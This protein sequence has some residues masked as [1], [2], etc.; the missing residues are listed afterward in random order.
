MCEKAKTTDVRYLV[1]TEISQKQAYIFRSNKLKENI[2]NSMVIETVLSKE[3]FE[4]KISSEIYNT[5]ENYVY[6]GGGHVILEFSTFEKAEKFVQSLTKKIHEEYDELEVF[7]K[8][9]GYDEKRAPGENLKNLTGCLEKKKALR[10]SA[11]HQG[12]FGIEKIDNNTLK[13]EMCKEDKVRLVKIKD[14]VNYV[15]IGYKEV[16]QFEKLGGSKNISNFIAVVHIDGNAMG[17]RVTDFYKEHEND[18]WDI[19]K[20]NIRQY[21]E[22]IDLDFK[23]AYE[24]MTQVVKANL[25]SGR[26]DSLNLDGKDFPVRKL[27][28]AGDDVCF[29]SEGRIGLSCAEAFLKALSTKVNSA[30]HQGYSACAGVAMVH[31]KFPFYRAYELSELL[32]S[33]AKKY[34][35]SL[36]EDGTGKELSCIDW[37]VEFGEN[38]DTFLEIRQDYIVNETTTLELRPYIVLAPDPIIQKDPMRQYKNFKK[39]IG[40]ILSNQI[41]YSKGRLKELR[42]VLKQGEIRTEYYLKF[43]KIS[44]IALEAYQDIYQKMTWDKIGTGQ[45]LERKVF[46][47]TMDGKT[48]SLLFDAIEL[49]D[50]YIELEDGK[51][52][53]FNEN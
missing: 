36:S 41:Q 24:E 8:I 20:K 48:H 5:T 18:T 11:F 29:V 38:K 10:S 34:G 45:G 16:S 6:S 14:K 28:L 25:E 15:P 23:K 7:A 1:V 40:S 21:S 3:Y 53:T 30:D 13:P 26:L 37:H 27:I 49:L 39:L 4:E 9:E 46:I 31:Q 32:C 52:D 35:A 22:S 19:F 33:N 50:T 43:H 47:R 42:N 17:A 44:D 51:E 2:H 12:T